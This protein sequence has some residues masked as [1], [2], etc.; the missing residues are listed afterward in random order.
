M[1]DIYN[2]QYKVRITLKRNISDSN[3]IILTN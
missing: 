2:L 1:L 3:L